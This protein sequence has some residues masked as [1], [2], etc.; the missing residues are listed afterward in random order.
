[1][2]E[3][4]CV[5]VNVCLCVCVRACVCHHSWRCL[6]SG[7]RCL[8]CVALSLKQ[9]FHQHNGTFQPLVHTQRPQLTNCTNQTMYANKTKTDMLLFI[10][11][12]YREKCN[13][14]TPVKMH[15]LVEVGWRCLCSA[16]RRTCQ[17]CLLSSVSKVISDNS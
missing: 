8:I 7:D 3:C 15:V 6:M 13:K 11:H 12:C 9:T 16:D 1:M 4:V 10:S 17:Y 14:H 5:C 2:A